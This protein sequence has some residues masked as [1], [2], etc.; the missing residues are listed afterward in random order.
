VNGSLFKAMPAPRRAKD[1]AARTLLT[2]AVLIALVPLVWILYEVI[3]Q[4]AGAIRGLTFFTEGPPGSPLLRGGGVANGII[5]TLMM[6]GIALLGAIPLG[7]LG[8]VWLVEFDHG[9]FLGRAV[10]FF[11]DVMTGIPSIVFGVFVYSM[12]VVATRSFSAIAGSVALGLIMWPVMLRASEE[13]LRLVPNEVREASYALGVPRWRTVLKVVLPTAA[14]GLVTA[15]MLGTARAAGETAP[16]L[17]TALGNQFVS[18]RVDK[19]M[20]ALPLEI[21]RGAT[22]AFSAAVERAWAAALTLVVLILVLTTAARLLT[23]RRAAG[24][25]S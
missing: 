11:G 15:V 6:V 19:P 14:S 25:R 4:G 23:A 3:R 10:R 16:L 8:A 22:T 13:V 7:I 21:F 18:F 9:S 20:S 5:G 1:V 2:F 12:I 17:F 24:G